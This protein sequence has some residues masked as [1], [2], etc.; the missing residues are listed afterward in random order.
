LG[1][2]RPPPPG[3]ISEDFDAQAALEE[4]MVNQALED[5]SLFGTPKGQL[6]GSKFNPS[7]S[8]YWAELSEDN[9]GQFGDYDAF[10]SELDTKFAS[11]QAA[12][13]AKPKDLS[14]LVLDKVED[15]L[16]VETE[17]LNEFAMVVAGMES[18]YGTNTN[19]PTS[20]AKGIYQITDATFPTAKN[21]LKKILGYLPEN[22][23]NA[24]KVD[25]LLE[26]D[27]K[28]LFFAHLSEDKGSD[29]KM[30]DYL[31]GRTSGAELY[32]F[33]HYKGIPTEQTKE[34]MNKFFK[35][36]R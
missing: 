36:V 28:A 1:I 25:D 15:R 26:D 20:T 17:R 19:N 2:F 31:E 21:R 6:T 24:A 32:K 16:G 34:R 30:I 29:S 18:D 5:G 27:Q 12:H 14:D 4:N 23:K 10:Q 13:P 8:R 7:D 22:I 11:L 3:T 9:M 33:N 35:R